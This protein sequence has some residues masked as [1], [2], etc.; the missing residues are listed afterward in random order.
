[1]QAEGAVPVRLVKTQLHLSQEMVETDLQTYFVQARMKLVQEEAEEG[2]VLL[3]LEQRG[4][5]A[6]EAEATGRLL[7]LALREQ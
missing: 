2:F 6:Q 3:I 4:L 1:V 5:A 7:K